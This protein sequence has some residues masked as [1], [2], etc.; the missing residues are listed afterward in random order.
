MKIQ[1]WN[2]SEY[3]TYISSPSFPSGLEGSPSEKK[4]K[5]P[6]SVVF[7]DGSI[8]CFCSGGNI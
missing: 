2:K 8:A 6:C 5:P 1:N 4:G 7:H 3:V